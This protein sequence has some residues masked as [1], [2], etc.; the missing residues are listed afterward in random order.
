MAVP[1]TLLV[2]LYHNFQIRSFQLF[3]KIAMLYFAFSVCLQIF[4]D[5]K[6]QSEKEMKARKVNH[7]NF[8]ILFH[9]FYKKNEMILAQ[10]TQ[11]LC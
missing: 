1:L 7:Q 9:N 2:C 5:D 6:S 3:P 4:E 8:H 11:L 10:I